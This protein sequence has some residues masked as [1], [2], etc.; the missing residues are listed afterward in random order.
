MNVAEYFEL[1][2]GISTAAFAP[3]CLENDLMGDDMPINS[4]CGQSCVQAID[5]AAML[6]RE[7][8]N[9]FGHPSQDHCHPQGGELSTQVI[10]AALNVVKCFIYG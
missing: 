5:A 7:I 3:E 6:N 9:A 8:Y 1:K 2:L 10:K 4:E